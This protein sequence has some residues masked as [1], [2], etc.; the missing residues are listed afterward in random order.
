M[1][2]PYVAAAYFKD[3]AIEDVADMVSA[4]DFSTVTDYYYDGY[5]IMV[6]ANAPVFGGTFHATLGYLDADADRQKSGVD[7]EKVEM[8]RWVLG[9]GYDY[10]LSK[11]TVIY[12]DAGY[13]R[14]SWEQKGKEDAD[15]SMFQAAVGMVHYF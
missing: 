15:P 4:S 9:F 5:G 1:V 8:N 13:A 10:N 3:G 6:G 11:R 12:A 7:F 14:D 2:K